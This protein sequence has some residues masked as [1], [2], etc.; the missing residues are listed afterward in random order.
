MPE[1]L[2]PEPL[3]RVTAAELTPGHVTPGMA[4]E[5]AVAAEGMWSGLVHTEPG[6]TSGW[7]HHG[8]HHTTIYVV[9]GAM[10]LEF[11]PGGGQVLDA[12]PGDFVHVPPEAV[13]REANP[14]DQ[15]ATAVIVRAGSGE[16]VV[17]VAG[18]DPGV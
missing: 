7:H 15:P 6:A 16:A 2:M 14:T 18:P 12:Q 17:N 9:R 11:G 8:D 4:R 10:R 3:R 1:P 13:H 5:E